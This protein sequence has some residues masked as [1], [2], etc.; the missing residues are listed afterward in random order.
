M[1]VT[2]IETTIE[3]TEEERAL[4]AAIDFECD[5]HEAWP[6]VADAMETLT[7][8]LIA[9]NAIPEHRLRYIDKPE[10]NVGGH[11]S[12]RYR[13]IERNGR[14]TPVLRNSA[15]L[16]QLRYLVYGPNLSNAVIE[17][18]RQRVIACGEPFTGSDA[19]N[20]ANFARHLTRLHELDTFNAPEEFYKLAL[21]C[22]MDAGDA[23]V[24][25]DSLIKA[26]R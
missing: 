4:L 1:R 20:V 5:D 18:F 10:H 22:G 16:K 8:L 13:I 19:L 21:D 23:R 6:A 9:R 24:V 12:S 11:G 17:S 7:R 25:R 2:L 3:L 26:R 15:F 14:S